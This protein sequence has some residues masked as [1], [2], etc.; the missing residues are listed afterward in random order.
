MD[1]KREMIN[2]HNSEKVECYT[3]I[4]EINEKHEKAVSKILPGDTGREDA[5]ADCI[6]Q[7]EDIEAN[8]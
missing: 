6:A 5:R 8:S 2:R 3:V 1:I 7:L 4:A